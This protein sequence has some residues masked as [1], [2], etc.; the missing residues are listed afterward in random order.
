VAGLAAVVVAVA[1][2]AVELMA[3]AA[4]EVMAAGASLESASD[5]KPC[6]GPEW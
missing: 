2:A 4:V 1:V 6:E 3:A 5:V